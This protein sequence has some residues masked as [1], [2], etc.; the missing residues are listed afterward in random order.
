[1]LISYFVAIISKLNKSALTYT[2][3]TITM[4]FKWRIK[5]YFY[6]KSSG[7]KKCLVYIVERLTVE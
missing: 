5:T 4:A 1:M 2:K 7:R 6:K 3:S